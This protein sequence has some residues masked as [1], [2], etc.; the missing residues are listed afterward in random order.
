MIGLV[1]DR[2]V[3][4]RKDLRGE[5]F[6]W[7]TRELPTYG[8]ITLPWGYRDPF[9]LNEHLF[10]VSY[11]GDGG[12]KSRLYLLD[13]R[14]NRKLIH[15]AEGK[16]GCFHPLP[17]RAR[18]RPPVIPPQCNNPEYV[19]RNPY[20]ANVD[21][22]EKLKGT[23]VL[24]DV[25]EGLRP[26]VGRGEVKALE[27]MEQVPKTQYIGPDHQGYSP[28][29]GRGTMFVRRIIGT[30][31][32][33]TDGS[34]HFTAP[35]IRDI[36]F[37]ALDAEGRVIRR[38]GSTIHV[39]PG[40]KL[41]CVGCHETRGTSPPT[42]KET[43]IAARRPPSVPR[44]PP[45]TEKGIID[46]TTVVQPVLDKH[47]IKC[48]SGRAPKAALDLSGDKTRFFN[49]AY[50]SL[51]DRGAVDY[52]NMAGTDHDESTAKDRGAIIS[53]IR[54]HL[55]TDVC[56][57]PL[58]LEDRQRIYTWIDASV[59]YYGTY[60][61]T[62]KR[63]IGSRDRW[64]GRGWFEKEFDPVFKRR[65]VGCHKRTIRHQTYNYN[66]SLR[67]VVTSTVWKE[68][69]LS[70]FG[71]GRYR[72]AFYGP[73]YRINLT[74]PEW[75][76]MLTAPLSKKAGG[77][78]LCKDRDGGA[79][80]KDASDPDYGLM[81]T[82]IRKGHEAIMA[83]PRVDMPEAMKNRRAAARATSAPG[84]FE[85]RKD[86][87]ISK[88]ATYEASSIIPRWSRD[89][90]KL[91]TG[92]PYG[93]RWAVCTEKEPNPW[94]VIILSNESDIAEVDIVNRFPDCR[95]F[96]RTLTM[97]LSTDKRS[98]KEVWRASGAR[99]RWLVKMAGKERARYVKLGLREK[100]YLD[101]KYVF[102][103]RSAR[104]PGSR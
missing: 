65:C 84:G 30:V 61:V 28:T 103:Y 55:E 70:Q 89:K 54:K 11:G 95:E 33:E 35:A 47:C 86:G 29:I 23:F 8:D 64:L 83:N 75:S 42:G 26:H 10:L 4:Y 6:R 60:N 49:M 1:W 34:A 102:V 27:I 91:L 19:H 5:G 81:L 87:W 96:A 76:Q 85:F 12:G 67:T 22:D 93:N 80:F 13:D 101:L 9:P 50:D 74:H 7:V 20:E 25:Y 77:L 2:P 71:F 18:K 14:G 24:Q 78:Q 17:L 45:W 97:W 99:D 31:P 88:N 16:L 53:K 32:V 40:E 79:V 39:M 58:P 44:Y 46:F 69:A 43:V 94:L 57:E 66:S 37:N 92:E 104:S 62:Q 15:E 68:Q 72:S 21:P 52:I 51:L 59:P 3:G 82:A 36:S 98:W 90:D 38:M 48:H 41:S 100:Q 56:C 73:D 63:G